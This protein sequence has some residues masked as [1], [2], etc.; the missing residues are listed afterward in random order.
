MS[1]ITPLSVPVDEDG[2]VSCAAPVP[3]MVPP[4]T[5]PP[6]RKIE[7]VP[8][9]SANTLLVRVPVRLVTPPVLLSVPSCAVVKAP[10]RLKLP[11][12]TRM[13]PLLLSQPPAK[14]RLPPPACRVPL[15]LQLL[16]V[17][18][19]VL[20]AVSALITPWL[21]SPKPLL[22]TTPPSAP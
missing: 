19:T 20:P 16:P 11:A 14:V 6:R 15:L 10:P 17:T 9:L 3:L 2:I 21:I 8:A 22:P 12:E 5:A 1:R 13:V 4:T 7:P 18:V